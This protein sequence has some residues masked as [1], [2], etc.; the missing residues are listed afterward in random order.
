MWVRTSQNLRNNL[1]ITVNFGCKNL[2]LENNL[3]PYASG[4]A[5]GMI[6]GWLT[7]GLGYSPSPRWHWTT[8]AVVQVLA[9]SLHE[10]L[11]DLGKPAK[12]IDRF[13]QH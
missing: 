10:V 6:A 11:W 7:L 9:G 4:N 3:R 2:K 12:R 5:Q 13:I 8:A 1:K